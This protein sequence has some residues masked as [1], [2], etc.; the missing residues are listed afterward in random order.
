MITRGTIIFAA[1][2]VAAMLVMAGTVST[3]GKTPAFK[4]HPTTE[5]FKGKPAIPIF[6]DDKI[7]PM[8]RPLVRYAARRGPNFAGAYTLVTFGC[9][10]GCQVV[11]VI[12]ARNGKIYGAPEAAT[13]G[14]SFRRNSRLLVLKADPIHKIKAKHYVFTKGKFRKLP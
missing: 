13:Y 4:D 1:S 11:L 6:E 10:T 9:G 8:Y 7:P 2:C 12:D 3:A 5:V 14:T